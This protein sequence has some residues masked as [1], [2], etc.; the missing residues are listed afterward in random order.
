[1]RQ[2]A[3][4]FMPRLQT[5]YQKQHQLQVS[6]EIKEQV[7]NDPDFLCAVVT[8]DGSWIF[9]YNHETKQQFQ[10]EG[11]IFTPA[12]ESE[13]VTSSVQSV[14]IYFFDTDGITHKDFVPPGQTINV[15]FDCSV[16]RWLRESMSWRWLDKW[17]TNTWVCRHDRVPA[18]ATLAMQ[19]FLASK[20]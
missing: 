1:M 11:T 6:V 19:Q 7:R 15:K 8:V 9:G 3:A 18:R 10:K 2:T 14:L 17:R 20:M 12:E 16:L 13:Q 5:D 4:K